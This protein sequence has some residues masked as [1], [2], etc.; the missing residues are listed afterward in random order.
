MRAVRA[1]SH[2]Q[3]EDPKAEGSRSLEFFKSRGNGK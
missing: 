2:V 3:D 1:T